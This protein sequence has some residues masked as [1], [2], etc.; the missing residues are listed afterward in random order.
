MTAVQNI[1]K[2]VDLAPVCEGPEPDMSLLQTTRNPCPAFPVEIFGPWQ[3][4]V[5]QT[6]KDASA[7]V[8]YAAAGLLCAASSL[9]GNSRSAH[10]W[11][12]WSEATALWIALV[13][14]PSSNKSPALDA[15]KKIL[16][17][18]EADLAISHEE[19]IRKWESDNEAANVR[20]AAWQVDVKKAV[21]DGRSPPSLPE[22]ADVPTKPGRPRLVVGDATVEAIGSLLEYQPKGLLQSRDELAGWL[23]SMDRYGGNGG[24][25]T[26][27]LESNGGRPYSIDRKKHADK[28]IIIPRLTL[29]VVGTIQPDRLNDALTTGCDDGLAARFLFVWPNRVAPERPKGMADH[30]LAAERLRRLMRLD[31]DADEQG[32]TRP[33]L[34]PLSSDAEAVFI[35]WWKSNSDAAEAEY[36]L[37]A[38]HVGKLPG[39]SLRLALVI[40][41]LAW[42]CEGGEEPKEISL[43]AIQAGVG[44]AT[45]Y[46]LPMA[47]RAFGDAALPQDE[48][49]AVALAKWVVRTKTRSFNGRDLYRCKAIPG[50]GSAETMKAAA[51]HLIEGNWLF[52]HDRSEGAKG[53]AR[54]DYVVNPKVFE[55]VRP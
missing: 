40:E 53:R 8:D 35:P 39:I 51:A 43:W 52:A 41:L 22:N 30:V 54:T 19:T 12:T 23:L 37:L 31:L 27:F 49:L 42:C 6:A 14:A 28:P 36:G 45:E 9:I 47:R 2:I 13:G 7:P 25:R 26:F 4:W 48:R 38:G 24:D 50:I 55:R 3:E 29:S 5:E 20:R 21:E 11:G 32:Q 1:Q 18:F 17:T 15:V 46:F 16:R 44:L 34:L 33:R 10:A